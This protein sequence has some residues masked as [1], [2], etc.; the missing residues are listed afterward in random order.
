MALL[1]YG[2]SLLEIVDTTANSSLVLDFIRGTYPPVVLYFYSI[3]EGNWPASGKQ[4][5]YMWQAR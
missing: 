3:E 2:A 4:L 5:H 1:K